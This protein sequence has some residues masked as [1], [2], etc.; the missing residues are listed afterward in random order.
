MVTESRKWDLR[1]MISLE[2]VMLHL[3]SCMRW[4]WGLFNYVNKQEVTG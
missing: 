1:V 2:L 4:S 3:F